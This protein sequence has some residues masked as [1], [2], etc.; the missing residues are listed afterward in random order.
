MPAKIAGTSATRNL[1]MTAPH[2]PNRGSLVNF[3]RTLQRLFQLFK[4]KI[5]AAG[6]L[7]DW[8]LAAAA[9][10]GRIRHLRGDIER[11]HHGAVTI[12]MNEI[13]GAHRHSGHANFAAEIFRVNIGVRWSDRARQRLEAGRPLRD[14]VYRNIGDDTER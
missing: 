13:A 5:L 11:N 2:M 4:R 7:K 12:G 9:Q 14:V 10:L 8:R 3:S 6:D 1:L